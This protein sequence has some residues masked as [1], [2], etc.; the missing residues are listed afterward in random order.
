MDL[1]HD[2]WFYFKHGK[3]ASTLEELRDVLEKLE[4]KEFKH[5]V[6]NEKNDFANWIEHVWSETKL[7]KDLREASEREGMVILLDDF[8]R[9]KKEEEQKAEEAKEEQLE[10]PPKPP[11]REPL[12]PLTVPEYH[13]EPEEHEEKKEKHKREHKEHKEHEHERLIIPE[14]QKISLEPEKELTETDIKQLVDEAMHVFEERHKEKGTKEA[15][16]AEEK[17][18]SSGYDEE[19]D[20]PELLRPRRK[21]V[22]PSEPMRQKFI[23]EEFIYGFVLGLIF[24]LIMLGILL[25]LRFG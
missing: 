11:I 23:F 17:E 14:D 4:D 25:N 24:G 12:P 13:G 19:E 22:L 9:G 5:H 6:T 18:E 7:A 2:K 3:R 16:E 15:D 21:S 1:P 8:I 20:E 10:E